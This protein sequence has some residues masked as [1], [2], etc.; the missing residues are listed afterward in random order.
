MIF[1]LVKSIVGAGVLGLPAG[2][3][4]CGSTNLALIPSIALISI[5]GMLSGY[6]FSLIG[7]ICAYTSSVS[8]RQAWE[9][10]VSAKTSWIPALACFMVTSCSV[11]AYSMILSD[12]IPTLISAFTPYKGVTRTQALLGVTVVALLPL[13]LTKSLKALG[14]FSLVGIIGMIYTSLAMAVRYFDGSYREGGKFLL[15]LP[16]HLIPNFAKSG[17]AKLV[18]I[19]LNPQLFILVS[20]LS[21]AYMV[22]YSM[23]TFCSISPDLL[24]NG[25]FIIL[26][27]AHYNASKFYWELENN[28]LKRYRLVVGTSF[29]ISLLLFV[30]VASFGFA[31]FG[32]GCAGLVLQNYSTSDTLM[33]LSRVAVALSIL[34]SYPLAFV[35]VREGLLD[36]IQVPQSKRSNKLLNAVTVVLLG[37]ITSMAYVVKDLRK[38]LA[39]NGATWG[40]AVIY[41]LPAYM[42]VSCV[43]TKL[44]KRQELQAEVPWVIATGFVGMLMGIIGTTLAIKG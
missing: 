21:T 26:T 8:Y 1:N 3:A 16:A 41:L 34:F 13:C 38:L 23:G 40:N 43:K 18:D 25:P 37:I 42:F 6:C 27:Q 12:T 11:L 35:G 30:A 15:T 44:P 14:P 20:M 10:S 4:A 24:A 17:S 28:T 19:I 2:V 33:S 9:R 22:W 7:R 32:T 36:L 31:T 5:I 39:F 29:G